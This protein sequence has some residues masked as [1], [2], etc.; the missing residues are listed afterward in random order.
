MRDALG[1]LC[2]MVAG[3]FKA[4]V[5]NLADSCMLSVPT[6]ITG[7]DYCMETVQPSDGFT[8][9]LQYDTEL[10]WVALVLHS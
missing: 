9:A 1:E 8:V 10:V 5:S 2:N 7:G 4:R 6:V 3:N